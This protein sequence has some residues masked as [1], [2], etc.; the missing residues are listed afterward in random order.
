[1]RGDS[2]HG[3][4]TY[5]RLS[6]YDST[7]MNLK[8]KSSTIGAAQ[9]NWEEVKEVELLFGG[10]SECDNLI[11]GLQFILDNLKL[12]RGVTGRMLIHNIWRR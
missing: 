1:M 7:D 12:Q 4:R 9:E 11:E 8:T 2:G 5:L 3:G 6:G 10:D